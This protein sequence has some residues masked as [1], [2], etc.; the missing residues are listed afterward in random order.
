MKRLVTGI[1]AHVD[2]GKT[3]C[4]ESMLY[5]SGSIRRLGRVDHK[6]AFLDYD[7]QERDRGITIYSKEACFTWKDTEI[8]VI[9]T[10]GHVDFSAEMERALQVLDLA[11]IL[12]NG[13]DGVQSHTETIWK[14]LEHYNVPAIL[15]VNKMDISYHTEEELLADLQKKCSPDCFVWGSDESME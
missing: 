11:V 15:F 13:Q 14:C 3:T 12:I 1:V 4:I 10:P 6:D 8:F 9:D 7:E 2:A 5:K